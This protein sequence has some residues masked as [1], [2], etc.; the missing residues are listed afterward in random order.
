ML[1]Y[2]GFKEIQQQQESIPPGLEPGF[3]GGQVFYFMKQNPKQRTLLMINFLRK[4]ERGTTTYYLSVY[5]I[6]AAE[7]KPP[8]E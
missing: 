2:D 7:I 1:A 3:G 4:S 8:Q 6:N 5:K